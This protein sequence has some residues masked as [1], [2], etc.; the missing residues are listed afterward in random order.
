MHVG[1]G[2]ADDDDVVCVMGNRGRERTCAQ[3]EPAHEAEADPARGEVPLDDGDLREIPL[4]VG[5]DEP[6]GDRRLLDER[7]GHDLVGN[8]AD[9]ARRATG[10]GD[11]EVASGQRADPHGLLHPLRH[12][13]TL[14][15][16]HLAATLEHELGLEA[17][18]VG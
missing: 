2:H 10:P 3:A 17:L 5:H 15:L 13:D 4:R 6:V 18:E 1:V 7:L 9:H 14:D 12:L 16:V 8:D 11:G